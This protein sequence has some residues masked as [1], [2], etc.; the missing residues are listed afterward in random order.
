VGKE[1]EK[2]PIPLL[3]EEEPTAVT[4]SFLIDNAQTMYPRK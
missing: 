3:G 1:I 2:L 4:I